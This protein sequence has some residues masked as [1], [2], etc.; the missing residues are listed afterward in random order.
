MSAIIREL[1]RLPESLYIKDS[2]E[3]YFEEKEVLQCLN[4]PG[5]CT[6]WVFICWCK[7][8][9]RQ[10]EMWGITVYHMMC[11]LIRDEDVNSH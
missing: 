6:G 7:I 9:C 4:S 5:G 11:K 3:M 2:A 1:V 10:G 8:V